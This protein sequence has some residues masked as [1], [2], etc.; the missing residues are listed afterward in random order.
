MQTLPLGAVGFVTDPLQ[1]N[2][3]VLSPLPAPTTLTSL[4]WITVLAGRGNDESTPQSA[5]FWP[6]GGSWVSKSPPTMP[7]IV[8]ELSENATPE[9]PSATAAATTAPRM[10]RP[11]MLPSLAEA[12]LR[13]PV[14]PQAFKT[15]AR[16]APPPRPLGP[17]FLL[18]PCVPDATRLDRSVHR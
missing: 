18:G 10:N 8:A 7:L 5:P 6:P 2:G 3:S 14:A 13:R 11:F 15:R 4:S 9:T 1:V 16:T 12:A 17:S